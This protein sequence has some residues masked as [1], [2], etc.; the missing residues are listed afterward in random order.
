MITSIG[1]SDLWN[2]D[3]TA[4]HRSVGCVFRARG[5]V[6]AERGCAARPCS[7]QTTTRQLLQPGAPTRLNPAVCAASSFGRLVTV[8]SPPSFLSSSR[9][10]SALSCGTASASAG[11]GLVPRVSMA[12]AM[13]TWQILASIFIKGPVKLNMQVLLINGC[14]ASSSRK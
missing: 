12:G 11:A 5:H 9:M 4:G 1:S 2:N 13:L 8:R 7:V 3:H 6:C 10:P 14:Y